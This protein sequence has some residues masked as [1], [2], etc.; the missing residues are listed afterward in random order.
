ML[1]EPYFSEFEQLV[2][3]AHLKFWRDYDVIRGSAAA[4]AAGPAAAA[5]AA[6]G[7]AGGKKQQGG[8]RRRVVCVPAAARLVAVAASLPELYRTRTALGECSAASDPSQ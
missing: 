3:W 1:S 8:R 2:P 5:G 6:A 4:A 7:A